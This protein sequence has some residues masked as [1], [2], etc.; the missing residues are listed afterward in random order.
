MPRAKHAAQLLD[1]AA[2]RQKAP[3]TF[4]DAVDHVKEVK[5]MEEAGMLE[6]ADRM[7]WALCS[8]EKTCCICLIFGHAGQTA[9]HHEPQA[10]PTMANMLR[11]EWDTYLYWRKQLRYHQ[12]HIKIC[13]TCHVPQINDTV[14][15]KF[16]K[17][18]QQ[19]HGK[20]T[21]QFADI[22]APTAFSIYHHEKLKASAEQHFETKWDTG[23]LAFSEWLMDKPT[24]GPYSNLVDLFMWYIDTTVA[25]A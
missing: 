18:K 22:L 3:A 20:P 23:I 2:I 25:A 24:K 13:W 10:C 16:T 17:V 11:I 4:S 14:H 1:D 9:G 5:V 8:V 15:P 19:P 12:H 21:C 7:L 6:A